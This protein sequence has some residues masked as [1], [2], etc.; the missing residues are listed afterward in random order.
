MYHLL[1]Q[2]GHWMYHLLPPGG[3]WMYHLLPQG[4]H[5]M[6]HLL[7]LK[8]TECNIYHLKKVIKKAA[9]KYILNFDF[10]DTKWIKKKEELSDG[11]THVEWVERL[12]KS[13]E[14]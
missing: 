13:I 5:W 3:H 2:G 10:A 1:P 4:S 12:L 14:L 7:P 11:S 6:Y 8:V 9:C